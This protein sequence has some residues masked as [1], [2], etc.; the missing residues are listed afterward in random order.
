LKKR[1][2]SARLCLETIRHLKPRQLFWRVFYN[3]CKPRRRKITALETRRKYGSW[4]EPLFK[5]ASWLGDLRFRFLNMELALDGAGGWNDPNTPKLWLYNLHYFDW[6]QS[7]SADDDPEGQFS[8][9]RLWAAQNPFGTGDAWEPYPVSLRIVNWVKFALRTG[10]LPEDLAASLALQTDYLSQRI[11]YDLLGNHVM[12]NAKGLLFGG[13]LLKGAEA[14]RWA[15]LGLELMR[16]QMDEQILPDGGHFERSAMYHSIILEDILDLVNLARAMG[17][18]VPAQWTDAL[19]R[20]RRWLLA[21]THDDGCIALFN[22]AAFDVAPQFAELE[23]YA[24]RLGLPPTVPLEAGLLPL[25]DSGYFRWNAGPTLLIGDVGALGPD[26]QLGHGHA[27]TLSFELSIGPDRLI[28]D[29]GTS[30]YAAGVERMQQRSTEAHNTV[31]IDGYD[32]S[33]VWGSF[34]VGRRARICELRISDDGSGICATHNGYRRLPGRPMH[35]RCWYLAVD[36]LELIDQILGE[37]THSVTMAFHFH[38]SVKFVLNGAE[39]AGSVGGSTFRAR[40]PSTLAWKIQQDEWHPRFGQQ[41]PNL[42]LVGKAVVHLPCS[43]TT[44]FIVSTP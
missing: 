17:Q 9:M 15:R 27:D 37:Q 21:M 7:A 16:L 40:L 20:M 36:G 41:L 38:P 33:E 3:C 10:T 44:R 29:S 14:N 22:D 26:Y 25:T 34:R 6:L 1:L 28:V 32:S 8:L 24:R 31:I 18:S 23:A 12:A 30:T 42:K 35:R 11:E 2:Q 43:F 4:Q 13:W 39:V 19:P 5:P